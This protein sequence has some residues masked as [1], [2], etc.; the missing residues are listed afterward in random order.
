MRA[1]RSAF[2]GVAL[3]AGFLLAVAPGANALAIEDYEF[4][5][6]VDGT[7]V[8]DGLAG[9]PIT[10]TY[11]PATHTWGYILAAPV[12]GDDWTINS[13]VSVYDTDPFVTNN[14]VLTN[15]SAVA[16][17]F[18]ISAALLIP[19]FAYNQVVAEQPLVFGKGEQFAWVR[20][21]GS[22]SERAPTPFT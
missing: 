7:V 17:N 18:T 15:N 2:A 12:S 4:S 14:I 11:D 22:R 3:A 10:S 19:A 5:L 6:S 9:L 20:L 8:Q 21:T 16:Q 1:L 13:W